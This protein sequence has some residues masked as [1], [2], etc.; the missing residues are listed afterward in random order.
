MRYKLIIPSPIVDAMLEQALAERPNEC[1]G[2]LAGVI[3]N[4]IGQVTHRFPLINALASP[5]AYLS[6]SKSL[7]LAHKEMRAADIE[8]LAVY[9]SH[10]TTA[11]IP[12]RTDCERN[13]LGEEMVYLIISLENLQPQVR[14]WHL[15]ESS[16]EEVDWERAEGDEQFALERPEV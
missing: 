9:H 14:A 2:L 16:F 8:V 12:S 7:L 5:R 11:A 3:A 4:G 13:Y 15:A 1:C 6:E 10:P